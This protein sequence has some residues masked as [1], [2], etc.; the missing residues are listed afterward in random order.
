MENN[1]KTVAGDTG[2]SGPR[3]NP[4]RKT[5]IHYDYLMNGYEVS[6]NYIQAGVGKQQKGRIGGAIGAGGYGSF[7]FQENVKPVP[8]KRLWPHLHSKTEYFIFLSTDPDNPDVT[9]G[10]CE[11]WIGEGEGAEPYLINKPTV[12][13]LPPNTLHLPQVFRESHGTGA[14]CV[15]YDAPLWM[16]SEVKKLPPDFDLIKQAEVEKYTEKKHQ[17]LVNEQDISRAAIFPAH[18]GKAQVILQHDMMQNAFTTHH[19]EANLISGSGIG[20]GCGDM[21]HFPDYRIRSFPHLHD[22]LETYCF[23]G[24]DPDNPDDLGGTIEFWLGEGEK[25]EKIII[26]KPTVLLI[27]PHTVHLPL[28]VN[29]LHHPIIS[30]AILDS[31]LWSGYYSDDFPAAFEHVSN[32]AEATPMQFNLKYDRVKCT[33]PECSICSDQCQVEG[34]DLSMDPPVIGEPCLECGQCALLCPQGAITVQL[35]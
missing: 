3:L 20:W 21:M 16:V 1:T 2:Q 24:T 8:I 7:K 25:A 13:V 35:Q 31:P 15:V 22:V 11:F 10:T 19:I 32:P 18:K 29:E 28:Y 26:N 4:T 23:M 30:V 14:M 34:I 9:G 33:Y 5:S 12:V 27:P 17:H 6:P